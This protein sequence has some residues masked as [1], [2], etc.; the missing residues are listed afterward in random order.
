M[1]VYIDEVGTGAVFGPLL[2]AAVAD[3]GTY[4]I[5][6]LK[7]S[8]AYSESKREKL[9]NILSPKLIHAFGAA[10]V[11]R[12]KTMNI[13]YAKFRAMFEAVQKL[14]KMGI[15]VDEVIVDGNFEIPDLRIKQSAVVK[16][17]EKFWPCA[18]A[19][20]LA[21]VV[22]DRTISRMSKISGY[23]CYDLPS[24]KGY[25]SPSHLK[26]IIANGLS[27]LHRRQH[28]YCKYALFEHQEFLKSGKTAEEYFEWMRLEGKP[29]KGSRYSAWKNGEYNSWKSLNWENG[30]LEA[31]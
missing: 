11:N 26:G 4:P 7:D 31:R 24:N 29:E 15:E 28:Q 22:R 3:N 1:K 6:R 16:A 2:V 17:D 30:K 13:H 18:A 21:K 5:E 9:F 20:I 12:I 10:N 19:S 25:Y 23:E 27:P 14:I 8:K